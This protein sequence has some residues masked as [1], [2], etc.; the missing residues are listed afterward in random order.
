MDS[1]GG[2]S[3]RRPPG[4]TGGEPPTQP[5]A[6]PLAVEASTA[7]P[8]PQ[9]PA[10]AAGGRTSALEDPPSEDEDEDEEDDSPAKLSSNTSHTSPSM[11][12]LFPTEIE[13]KR[14][15]GNSWGVKSSAIVNKLY[16]GLEQG[17]QKFRIA[18]IL[19]SQLV[20][21]LIL[22]LVL[23]D[24]SL[25]SIEVGIY[26]HFICINGRLVPETPE[27]AATME[28]HPAPHIEP[29]VSTGSLG[30]GGGA[31]LGEGPDLPLSVGRP[32]RVADRPVAVAHAG[33]DYAVQAATFPAAVLL[34]RSMH[35][36]ETLVSTPGGCGAGSSRA[37]A[38]A[39]AAG[40]TVRTS[41]A[42][43]LSGSIPFA[44]LALL[45]E[46]GWRV[47]ATSA[48]LG[49]LQHRFLARLRGL[50]H[51][52]PD[53]AGPK[54][55]LV[56]ED[57]NGLTAH[58]IMLFCDCFSITILCAF[59]AELLSKLWV[60][61]QFFKHSPLHC[62]DLAVVSM[63]LAADLSG[64]L[65]YYWH[66]AD[67]DVKMLEILLVSI[68]LWR[69]LRIFHTAFSM[70]YRSTAPLKIRIRTQKEKLR[71]AKETIKMLRTL[72]GLHGVGLDD[73]R[74]MEKDMHAM[75][76]EIMRTRGT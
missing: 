41:G 14:S 28:A 16:E 12:S 40:D 56:C 25:V 18:K 75:N 19:E 76:K 73:L 6:P 31:P 64:I 44:S 7:E 38:A 2:P 30:P 23:L 48:E 22:F 53:P 10:E 58:V 34:Q 65:L 55:K 59:L 8:P 46:T 68:R 57:K 51:N 3:E 13:H 60:H 36:V 39:G 50:I 20:E 69:I 71:R 42:G 33:G 26:H 21:V 9:A 32:M 11:S 62:M 29:P 17:T 37:A 15:H 70:W 24:L 1:Q 35:S 54:M 4:D 49:D 74:S 66:V 43:A 47:E 27:M 61:P 5:P 72:T 45:G 52:A 67:L 63:S